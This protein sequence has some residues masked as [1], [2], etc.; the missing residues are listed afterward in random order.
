M[1]TIISLIIANT[2][3][4]NIPVTIAWHIIALFN[5]YLFVNNILNYK[6]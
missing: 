1:A 6:N 4:I 3:F 2:L 5:A